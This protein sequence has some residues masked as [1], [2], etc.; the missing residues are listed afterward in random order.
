MCWDSGNSIASRK[1]L[2]ARMIRIETGLAGSYMHSATF[3]CALVV[4]GLVP[5]KVTAAGTALPLVN[6]AMQGPLS[7]SANDKGVVT[8]CTSVSDAKSPLRTSISVSGNAKHFLET[9]R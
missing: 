9:T 1:P 8:Y 7:F 3:D 4:D 6:L 2:Y 5:A